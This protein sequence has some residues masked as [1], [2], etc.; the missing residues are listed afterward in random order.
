MKKHWSQRGEVMN[1]LTQLLEAN[2][3]IASEA[4]LGTSS[5][6]PEALYRRLTT[7]FRDQLQCAQSVL[8]Y[9]ADNVSAKNKCRK[10]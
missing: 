5:P 10:T 2:D 7:A 8:R 3:L 4:G 9:L 1:P 6:Y